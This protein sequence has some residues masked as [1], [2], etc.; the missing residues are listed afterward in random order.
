MKKKVRIRI[1][2]YSFVVI[3]VALYSALCLISCDNERLPQASYVR[4]N[5]S[6]PFSF[7]MSDRASF[8]YYY[9][10]SNTV[11]CNIVYPAAIEYAHF[12]CTYHKIDSA[13]FRSLS[14][15]T[16]KLAYSHA[17]VADSITEFSFARNDG[18]GVIMFRLSGNVATPVQFAVTDSTNY[19]FNA[20][21][22]FDN[23]A[24]CDTL[25]EVISYLQKDIDRLIE[26]FEL[27]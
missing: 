17:I 13:R 19:F 5:D 18:T 27:K 24:K 10:D 21:L 20:S 14:E 2:R 4:V 3:M 11:F 22:Y 9:R 16:Y 7:E 1:K 25:T 26:T 23:G 8:N 15:D 12:Y 6:L